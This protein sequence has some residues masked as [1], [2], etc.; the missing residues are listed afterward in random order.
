MRRQTKNLFYRLS[1]P[2]FVLI[3]FFIALFSTAASYILIRVQNDHAGSMAEQSMM[4]VYRN[5]WYQFDTMNN[6]AAFLLSNQSVE[7]LLENRHDEP[8]EGVDDFFALQANLQNL[9]L[10]PLLNGYTPVTVI[11]PSYV[12]SLALEPGSGLYEVAPEHFHHSTGI[13]KSEDVRKE[14]WYRRLNRGESQSVWWGQ[15][16]DSGNM[17]YSARKKTSI[18]DGSEIGSVLVGAYTDSLKGVFGNAPIEK[19]YHVLLDETGRVMYSEKYGFLEPLGGERYMQEVWK[20]KKGNVTVELDGRRHRLLFDTFNNGWK[21]MAVVPESHLNRYTFAVSLIGAATAL[22]AL[23]VA[24]YILRKIVVRVTVPITRLVQAMQ[25]PEVVAFKEPLPKTRTGIYEVDELNQ[26]FSSMLVTIRD[27]IRKSYDEEIE[28]R[29][30]QLELL[31][32]Q[33]NPHFL[34]NTLDLINCRALL[35]GDQETSSIVRSLAQVFRYGL[36]KG[37]TWIALQDEIRQVA[38]YLDIQKLMME[39]LQVSYEV[40]AE[41]SDVRVVH[42]LLQPLAE[43]CI[44]HGFGDRPKGCRIAIS[45]REEEGRLILRVADNGRGCDSDAMNRRLAAGNEQQDGEASA[46]YGTL[47]VHRRIRLHCGEGFGLRYLPADE[48]TC[49]EAELPLHGE[50]AGAGELPGI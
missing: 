34:Y 6:M 38:A 11:P 31:Q 12:V 49:V 37:K 29:Q 40:P 16:T 41:L 25:R 18:K 45:A 44:V 1:L 28:K 24:G 14:D 47:N 10:I 23:L 48:G 15:R 21:L 22:S 19:G 35:S 42:L 46:G 26:Q 30:L 3:V 27:L 17:L 2:L 20:T 32:A 33:I 39:D 8:F 43:N 9:S 5:V 7:N 4:F 13:Y 36:N 50:K